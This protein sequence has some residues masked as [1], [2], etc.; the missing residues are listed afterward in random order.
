M[1]G[2]SL[3]HPKKSGVTHQ[4]AESLLY[5]IVAFLLAGGLSRAA[6]HKGFASAIAKAERVAARR[7]DHIGRPL[8][9]ADIVTRWAHDFRFVDKTGRPRPLLLNGENEFKG[10][11]KSIDPSLDPRLVLSVLIRYGN[12]R[13][14]TRQRYALVR[15]YFLT[16]RRSSMAY[17][18]IAYFLSDAST[19]LGRILKRRRNSRGPAPLWRKVEAIGLSDTAAAE[20]TEFVRHRSIDFLEELDDWLEARRRRHIKKHG[21]RKARRVGVGL[22]SIYSNPEP[23]IGQR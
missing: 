20:F 23:C 14:T 5:P 10:L 21:Q 17:E 19:T 4:A 7:I 12:V 6:A 16:S 22:F 1:L 9:Y 2:D 3:N 8:H 18:P 15:Q 13:K 11:V